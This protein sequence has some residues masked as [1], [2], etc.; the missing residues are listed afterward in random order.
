MYCYHPGTPVKNI[1][2]N[3]SDITDFVRSTDYETSELVS[4]YN[5]SEYNTYANHI[6]TYLHTSSVDDVIITEISG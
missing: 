4:S 6:K 3:A 2:K 1:F 5:M